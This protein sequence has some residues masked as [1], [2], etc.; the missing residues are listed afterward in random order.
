MAKFKVL[1]QVVLRDCKQN[2]KISSDYPVP[3][4]L[5]E[6]GTSQIGNGS[7]MISFV[8]YEYFESASACLGVSLFSEE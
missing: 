2:T 3:G 1:S 8:L 5:F 4:P 6:V 7:E